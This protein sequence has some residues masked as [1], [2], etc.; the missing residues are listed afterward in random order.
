MDLGHGLGAVTM[1]ARVKFRASSI[2]S[3]S[4]R[5][6]VRVSNIGPKSE[7]R[8]A[9]GTR[10]GAALSMLRQGGMVETQIQWPRVT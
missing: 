1:V 8:G 4:L 6:V 7:V 9:A 5:D 2:K 10:A 3:L